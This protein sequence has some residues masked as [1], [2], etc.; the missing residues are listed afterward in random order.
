MVTKVSW[1]QV[2]KGE[3]S[4]IPN[5]AIFSGKYRMTSEEKRIID[6]FHNLYYN[7]LKGEG[8]IFGRT[9]WMNVPCYKCPLDL[10]IYQEILTEV[11]PDL[12]IETGTFMGGSAL[13]MAHMLD[14][15]GRGEIITID[16]EERASR[17]AHPRIRYVTGSSVDAGLIQSMLVDRSDETRLVVLDADHS[18]N[19]VLNELY[20]LSSYVSLGSY[21]I[22]EDTNVNGH[23]TFASYGEGPYEAV[24]EFLSTNTDFAVD[25]SKEKFLLTFNPK[26]YLKRVK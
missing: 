3:I 19:H 10:W 7:G 1:H 9:Y 14:I 13:Y 6:E 22:V 12:I 16:I 17:P 5:K 24:E 26:G 20:L 25:D 21:I 2:L 18:R 11:R 23:P 15:I 4:P 8:H